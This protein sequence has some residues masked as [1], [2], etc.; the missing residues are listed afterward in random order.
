MEDKFSLV[1]IFNILKKRW[2]LI[3]LM[4]TIVALISGIISYFVLTPIYQVSTQILVNQKDS[5]NYLD[6]TL[7]NT[8]IDLINTYSVII[9]S[10]TILE[11]VI[12]KLDLSQSVEQLNQ[13]ISINSQENSQVF[14]MTVENSNPVK[15]VEIANTVSETFQNEIQGIMNVDNVSI[16]SKA[17]LTENPT[18]VKPN[19]L[20]N[21][22]IA[23]VISLV[24]GIVLAFILELL[25]NT[26]KDGHEVE[27]FL[28]LPVL[29]S[30]EKII[31]SKEN[32]V[33][34]NSKIQKVGGETLET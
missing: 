14:T 18:P 15:A 26:L 19:P 20:M 22:A 7:L 24:V 21:I 29:G 10:P 6:I 2:K 30:I 34:S 27:A 11:K 8:N 9:K 32:D 4:T 1:S 16:L 33:I 13:N 31:N 17:K 23:I 28:G 3:V 5:E 25:D 12:E